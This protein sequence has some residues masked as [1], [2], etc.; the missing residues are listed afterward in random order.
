MEEFD[1]ELIGWVQYIHFTNTLDQRFQFEGLKIIWFLWHS[2]CSVCLFVCLSICL[3]LSFFGNKWN[4]LPWTIRLINLMITTW[5]YELIEFFT[6]IGQAVKVAKWTFPVATA[7]Y[8]IGVPN[9]SKHKQGIALDYPV[10]SWIEYFLNYNFG[11]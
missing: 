1:N 4:K 11:K 7:K 3:S 6:L 9:R 8:A 5:L 2:W 10:L